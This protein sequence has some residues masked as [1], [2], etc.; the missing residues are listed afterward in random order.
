[1]STTNLTLL[2]KRLAAISSSP[3]ALPTTR[4][5]PS[6]TRPST[7]AVRWAGPPERLGLPRGD[8]GPRLLGN[9]TGRPGPDPLGVDLGSA[10]LRD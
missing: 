8:H 5:A 4:P 9:G 7:A 6:T 1:M 3:G 2:A 10:G